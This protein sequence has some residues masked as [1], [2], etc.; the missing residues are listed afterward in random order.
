MPACIPRVPTSATASRVPAVARCSFPADG[1]RNPDVERQQAQEHLWLEEEPERACPALGVDQDEG[2]DRQQDDREG[3]EDGTAPRS[4]PTLT[5]A[6]PE[7]GEP[8]GEH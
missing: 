4:R 6:R 7:E 3:K 8:G 5:K 1:H 2:A